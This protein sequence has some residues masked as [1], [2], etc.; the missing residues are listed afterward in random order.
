MK[1]RLFFSFVALAM[2]LAVTGLSPLQ[3]LSEAQANNFKIGTNNS[4]APAPQ[5][6]PELQLAPIN[7]GNSGP[8]DF[9]AA[10]EPQ[11]PPSGPSDFVATPE[12]PDGPTENPGA[13][14]KVAPGS[15]IIYE[16]QEG[17]GP[18]SDDLFTVSGTCSSG[19]EVYITA[20]IKNSPVKV[21]CS[22]GK[23]IAEDLMWSGEWTDPQGNPQD[24]W[25]GSKEEISA[26]QILANNTKSPSDSV[27]VNVIFGGSGGGCNNGGVFPDCEPEGGEGYGGGCFDPTGTIEIEC[28]TGTITID[29]PKNG[30]NLK[31]Q[32]LFTISGKCDPYQHVFLNQQTQKNPAYALCSA[33]GTYK[34]DNLKWLDSVE[35]GT[36]EPISA[37]EVYTG[38]SGEKKSETVNITVHIV[39]EMILVLPACLDG[40]DNDNDN[41]IDK[42]DPGCIHDGQYDPQD[43]DETDEPQCSDGM[44]ND[45]DGVMDEKDPGC[46]TDGDPENPG[47]YD[48]TDPDEGGE[49]ACSDNKDND[50]D[51]VKDKKD[52]GCHTD[53]N[54]DNE[55]SY[56]PKD[57]D[58]TDV[59]QCSDGKDNDNDGVK[60]QNDP[61]CMHDGQYDPTDPDETDP[62]KR[63]ICADTLDNDNDGKID[64]KDPGCH[65]DGN[66]NNQDSYDPKDSDETNKPQ[67]ADGNDNDNDGVMDEKDP[68]CHTDNNPNNPGSYD[69]GD[70]NEGDEPQC[71]DGKDNDN[72]KKVDQKDPDCHSDG[73]PNN[74]GSYDPSDNDEGL[75]DDGS[76]PFDPN[77]DYVGES[78]REC[79]GLN[80]QRKLAFSDI[81]DINGVGALAAITL[82][83]T[84]LSLENETSQYLLSGY[85]SDLQATGK[86][87]VGLNNPFTRIELAK[88]IMLSHCL[89]I[90]D[91]DT[92]P[93]FRSNGDPMISYL[94]LPRS[95]SAPSTTAQNIAYSIQYYSGPNEAA[96]RGTDAGNFEPN[97]A[98]QVQELMKPITMIQ[99][100]RTGVESPRDNNAVSAVSNLWS[101]EFYAKAAHQGLIKYVPNALLQPN[102]PVLRKNAFDMLIHAMLQRDLYSNTDEATINAILK[103]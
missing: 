55:G 34:T 76:I 101:Y 20:K 32:D 41:K 1:N 2:L 43:P 89:P 62:D 36:N 94:D 31:K 51:G 77:D 72:D 78:N 13:K 64:E 14:D 18:F 38:D 5:P 27:M 60:D 99:E 21:T 100:F 92:L 3:Q 98:I 69:P 54:P 40:K 103:K 63:F 65:T 93:K 70:N 6:T 23:F 81:T 68:G 46:H 11:A 35:E 53:G 7:I 45:N 66:P 12:S 50:T 57:N 19:A 96:M 74:P 87:V 56:D 28:A 86:T 67:C 42:L 26:Y 84:Y 83:N 61:G 85:A 17:S 16:P 88:L 10:P 79:L 4:L 59:P 8:S 37:Y 49:L 33:Q 44:D 48:P 95:G 29:D 102:Q 25:T 22:A 80:T 24:G 71:S 47:T 30:A 52:P 82:K 90:L 39:K 9:V 58:E 73:N 91:E 75:N 97:R 15:V